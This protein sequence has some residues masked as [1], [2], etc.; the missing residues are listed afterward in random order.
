VFDTNARKFVRDI[1]LPLRENQEGQLKF[2]WLIDDL[3]SGDPRICVVTEL[4]QYSQIKVIEFTRFSCPV[5]LQLMFWALRLTPDGLNM[6]GGPQ[7]LFGPV[8]VGT[9][10]IVNNREDVAE[11]VLMAGPGLTVWRIDARVPNQQPVD[12]FAVAGGDLSRYYDAFMWRGVVYLL[13]ASSA[14]GSF[15]WTSLTLLDLNT[16]G[17]P[18]RVQPLMPDPARGWPQVDI[19]SFSE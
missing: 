16:R 4:N 3:S 11:I 12:S 14:D 1:A 7:L 18:M 5:F 17:A 19:F 8:P 15:D 13:A 2:M 6:N 10:Y 9:D